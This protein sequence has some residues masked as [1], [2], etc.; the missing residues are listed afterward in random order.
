MK[1]RFIQLG[2]LLIAGLMTGCASLPRTAVPLEYQSSAH[3]AGMTQVRAIS[4]Q[5][6]LFFEEDV[7]HSA[8]QYREYHDLSDDEKLELSLL[9]LSG[10]ADYGA[11]GAGLLNGWSESG[12]RP[13]FKLVTGVS[14]GALIAPFAYLGSDYD[15]LLKEVFTTVNADDIFSARFLGVLWNDGLFDT[16]PLAEL[17]EL[18]ITRDIMQV[19]ALE[20]ARGRRLWIATT[21]LDSDR[22]VIWD[23]GKIA[24]SNHPDALKLFRRVIL[25]STSIPGVFPPVMIDVEVDGKAYDEMHVDGGVKAQLFLNAETLNL[26]R[27]K[28]REENAAGR[29][30]WTFYIV[31][32]AKVGPEPQQIERRISTIS[33]RAM[34]SLLKSQGRSDM[35]RIYTMG[36]MA[37]VKFNWTS[38]PIEYIPATLEAFDQV[39]MNTMFKMGYEQGLR[40]GDWRTR[41]P[42]IGHN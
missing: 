37:D 21:N 22:L 38:L 27:L 36:K 20:N 41:P 4:G 23:M 7:L 29:P 25:A 28:E 30:E 9:V 2:I 33:S 13:E 10:G 40:G 15:H 31:R 24:Q 35:E 32:N 6:N 3:I 11:F 16:T 34:T 12:T 8:G 19:V 1:H 5:D 39:E 26:I 17:I 42:G 18:Y 14:T